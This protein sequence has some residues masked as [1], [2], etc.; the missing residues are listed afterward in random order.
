MSL[1]VTMLFI[2]PAQNNPLA[3]SYTWLRLHKPQIKWVHDKVGS[4]NPHCHSVS[5]I[6]AGRSSVSCYHG[7]SGHHYGGTMVAL[8]NI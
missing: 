3:L 5:A 7:A 6:S 1:L 8:Y 2:F 4:W